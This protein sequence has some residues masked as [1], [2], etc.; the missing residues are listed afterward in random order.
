[1]KSVLFLIVLFVGC[2]QPTI[3]KTKYTVVSSF[4]ETMLETDEKAKAYE[5]AHNL[6]M[7]GRVFPSKPFYLVLEK[8]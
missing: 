2:S 4:N 7:M 1:M 6:T 3:S 5:T 8:K